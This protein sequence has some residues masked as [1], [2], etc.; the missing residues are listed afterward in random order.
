MPIRVKKAPDAA[1]AAE[2]SVDLAT[3]GKG[4]SIRWSEPTMSNCDGGPRRPRHA[5]RQPRVQPEVEY[6]VAARQNAIKPAH[7]SRMTS[8]ASSH[9]G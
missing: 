2:P 6:S 5:S 1:P 9:V 4:G 7:T 3:R 8:S